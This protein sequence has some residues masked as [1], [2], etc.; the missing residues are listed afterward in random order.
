MT[1]PVTWGKVNLASVPAAVRKS[2]EYNAPTPEL[3][4]PAQA[5]RHIAYYYA[6]LAQRDEPVGTVLPSLQQLSLEDNTIVVYTSGHGEMPGEHG[7]WQKL[8]LYESSCGVPLLLRALGLLRTDVCRV[9]FSQVG[10][11]PSLAELANV[12]VSSRIAA[13]QSKCASPQQQ[14]ELPVFAECNP[15]TRGATYMV[16]SG[17]HKYTLCTHDIPE[18]YALGGDPQEINTSRPI[19]STR[20]K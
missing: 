14:R 6:N 2:I 4:E 8:Q 1:V 12:P 9:P 11:L 17:D 18:L 20:A 15:R 7:P 16:R 10:L 3:R 19:V 5:R 13:L